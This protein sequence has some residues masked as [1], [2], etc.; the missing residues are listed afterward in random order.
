MKS[1]YW[2]LEQF[3]LKQTA[4]RIAMRFD[5]IETLIG[6]KLPPSAFEHRPWWAN[7]AR[8]HSHAKAWLDA[9]FQTSE[10]DMAARKLTFVSAAGDSPSGSRNGAP[11]VTPSSKGAGRHPLFGVLKG[12]IT[13]ETG[14]DLTSPAMPEWA[15]D[16]DSTDD[17]PK[18]R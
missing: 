11:K 5:Q 6:E 10:V 15:D 1:K 17:P 7:E 4:S 3:L 2:P 9:K 18:H 12:L 14:Y 13:I 8:G 16:L